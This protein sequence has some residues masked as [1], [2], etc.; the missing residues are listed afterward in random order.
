MNNELNR[1]RVLEKLRSHKPVLQERFGVKQL[2]LV[3][4]IARGEDGG[5][6]DID[7]IVEFV[8]PATAD[9]FF[10][11]H[12]YLEDVFDCEVDLM[13]EKGLREGMHPYVKGK[14]ILV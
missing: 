2:S 13:T 14:S 3:G 11:A 6:N 7:L 5:G 1:D 8:G 10:G 4:S 12:A 9:G